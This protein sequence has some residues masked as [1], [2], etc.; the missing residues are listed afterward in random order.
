MKK[1][2]AENKIEHV[3]ENEVWIVFENEMSEFEWESQRKTDDYCKK[4]RSCQ[5]WS[6]N[7]VHLWIIINF[8][9]DAYALK[10]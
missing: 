7:F 5:I 10:H 4:K 2:F 6:M 9:I 1:I 8:K 3:F